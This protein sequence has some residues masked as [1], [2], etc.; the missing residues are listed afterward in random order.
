MY[1]VCNKVRVVDVLTRKIVTTL[2]GHQRSVHFATAAGCC[3]LTQSDD[4]IILWKVADWRRI[5]SL[6][7]PS[8]TVFA[9]E[10]T[11]HG[12]TVAILY[13]GSRIALWDTTSGA[14][15]MELKVPETKAQAFESLQRLAISQDFVVAST[16]S[17]GAAIGSS[18]SG[19]M[20]LWRLAEGR[21]S[22]NSIRPVTVE[23]QI[24]KVDEPISQL[25]ARGNIIFV[26]HG[27]GLRAMT[28]SMEPKLALDVKG[29]LHF[30][31]DASGPT[32][33]LGS[34]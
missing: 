31:L 9:A 28:M 2:L 17:D 6:V 5:R 4:A 33:L 24:H 3:A 34:A 16:A 30:G 23:G 7:E 8:S 27:K 1:S 20:V 15:Q 32:A 22:L 14:P 11:P 25:L 29:L 12:E 18:G 26:V 21:A 13:A 10:L 19:V